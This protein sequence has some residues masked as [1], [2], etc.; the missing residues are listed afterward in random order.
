MMV[1][2]PLFHFGQIFLAVVLLAQ[3]SFE[4]GESHATSVSYSVGGAIQSS[5]RPEIPVGALF[6]A[7]FTLDHNVTDISFT[8]SDAVFDGGLTAFSLNIAGAGATYPGGNLTSPARVSALNETFKFSY[9]HDEIGLGIF[10]SLGHSFT[11]PDLP[12]LQ[13]DSVSINFVENVAPR[14]NPVI[15]TGLGQTM[16]QMFN[17]YFNPAAF[18]AS[19]G[20]ASFEMLFRSPTNPNN[21]AS[22]LGVVSTTQVTAA[23]GDSPD[24]PVFSGPC[25]GPLP[26]GTG[27]FLIP[28]I[29]FGGLGTEQPIWIDPPPTSGFE[30]E[31]ESGPNFASVELE[32]GF[33][34]DQYE[35]WVENGSGGF[36]FLSALSAGMEYDFT[37][38]FPEGLQRFQIRGI[39]PT[40]GVGSEPPFGF[41]TGLKFVSGGVEALVNMIPIAVPEPA[42]GFLMIAS[43]LGLISV[44]RRSA[45][46]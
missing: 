44:R 41:P 23:P 29:G 21:Q 10:R 14:I 25:S 22:I 4:A 31:V 3:T 39:E 17:G 5:P 15:D 27:C 16:Q 1:R 28:L 8:S 34:D 46:P 30:Y 12:G 18:F 33:G 42:S 13:L 43:V 38:S 36:E 11:M 2:S 26:P 45:T 37:A 24:N 35:V 6:A 20:Y 19:G 32:L 9:Q 40:S 7:T